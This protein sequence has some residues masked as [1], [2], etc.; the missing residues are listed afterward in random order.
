[1]DKVKKYNRIFWVAMVVAW[2][3]MVG[4][5]MT[6]GTASLVWV[7]GIIISCTVAGWA[8]IKESI[9][10]KISEADGIE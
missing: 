1:M 9:A 4:A 3:F 10:K 8:M 7:I 2:I 6:D 5:W